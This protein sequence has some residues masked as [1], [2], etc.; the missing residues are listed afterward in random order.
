ML[1]RKDCD[2]ARVVGDDR[3]SPEA[4]GGGDD[5]GIDRQFAPCLGCGKQMAGDTGHPRACGYDLC[6]P[7]ARS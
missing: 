2:V 1:C 4:N 6:E 5:K 3:A 7:R